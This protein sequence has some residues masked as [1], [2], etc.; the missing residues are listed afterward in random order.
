MASIED[1]SGLARPVIAPDT[2]T[3]EDLRQRYDTL[4]ARLQPYSITVALLPIACSYNFTIPE[5][6]Q[7]AASIGVRWLV[8]MPYGMFPACAVEIDRFI[9]HMLEQHPAQGS[10]V[11][12]CGEGWSIPESR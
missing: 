3:A 2:A 5:A 12:E 1:F 6:A 7:L 9:E 10:K 11:F 8:P 4:A